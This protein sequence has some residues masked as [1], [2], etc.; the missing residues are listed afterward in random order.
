M[1]TSDIEVKSPDRMYV[2]DGLAEYH[3]LLGRGGHCIG[4]ESILDVQ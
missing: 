4:T 3:L 2:V 1:A